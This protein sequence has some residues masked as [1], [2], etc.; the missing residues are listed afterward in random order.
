MQLYVYINSTDGV[1]SISHPDLSH[2]AR[3]SSSEVD[4][5]GW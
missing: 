2:M 5:V 4:A 3:G 1:V